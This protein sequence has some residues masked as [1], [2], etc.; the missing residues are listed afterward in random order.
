MSSLFC[1]QSRKVLIRKKYA[2]GIKRV[3]RLP[4]PPSPAKQTSRLCQTGQRRR[5]R[6]RSMDERVAQEAGAAGRVLREHLP[7]SVGFDSGFGGV[8]STHAAI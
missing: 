7:A 5:L 2:V 1:C 3:G 6:W 8:A 4:S